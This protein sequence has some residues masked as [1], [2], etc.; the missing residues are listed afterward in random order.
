MRRLVLCAAGAVLAGCPVGCPK[1]NPQTLYAGPHEK[2]HL[3]RLS[4][5]VYRAVP[6][7]QHPYMPRKGDPLTGAWLVV[8]NERDEAK[9][10]VKYDPATATLTIVE[11]ICSM[12][13]TSLEVSWMPLLRTVNE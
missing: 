12:G 3:E 11:E 13:V 1:G 5:C 7:L 8:L 2:V 10:W 4:Q 9:G 6:P